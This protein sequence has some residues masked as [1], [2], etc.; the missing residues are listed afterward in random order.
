MMVFLVAIAYIV[1]L[2]YIDTPLSSLP[3]PK[4]TDSKQVKRVNHHPKCPSC[5]GTGFT[6]SMSD[7]TY[8]Y[9]HKCNRFNN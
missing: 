7:N 5:N 4:K 2:I 9:C 3:K 8:R 1:G 6:G